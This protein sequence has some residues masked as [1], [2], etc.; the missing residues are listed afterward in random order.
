MGLC[1]ALPSGSKANKRSQRAAGQPRGALSNGAVQAAAQF[2]TLGIPQARAL[3]PYDLADNR[4]AARPVNAILNCAN[5]ALESEIRL[6]A[7]SEGYDPTIG[8]MHEGRDGSSKFVF[9]L[10]EPERTKVDRAVLDSVRSQV[11][12][13][14]QGDVTLTDQRA[15]RRSRLHERAQAAMLAT[16]FHCAT[17][18]RR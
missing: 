3:S 1:P 8:I 11:F 5:A 15:G 10:M 4:N 7:I 2:P 14:A 16:A 6:K 13:P 17:A 12:S 9:D 18:L